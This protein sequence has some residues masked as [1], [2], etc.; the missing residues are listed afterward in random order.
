[1]MWQDAGHLEATQRAL[2]LRPVASEVVWGPCNTG[3]R[4]AMETLL[5]LLASFSRH[6]AA[7]C[8]PEYRPGEAGG[9]V[10][11]QDSLSRLVGSGLESRGLL[12]PTM[13]DLIN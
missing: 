3:G 13:N 10:V 9:E 11:Q 12:S 2:G 5:A 8:L 7:C 4:C 6:T 1:M